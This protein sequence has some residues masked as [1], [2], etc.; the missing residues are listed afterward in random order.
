MKQVIFCNFQNKKRMEKKIK[1]RCPANIALI[2]YWGK[3]PVQLPCNPSLSMTLSHSFTDLELTLK[4][5][6]RKGLELV[7]LFDNKP[8]KAFSKRILTYLQDNKQA[9]PF[10]ED[11]ALQINT[12]NSFPYA[13]GIA[14]S[15]SAFG[16]LALALMSVE[17]INQEH[18]KQKASYYARLGSGS[19]CRSIYGQFALWGQHPKAQNSN[20]EYA[21]P[22]H[23][24]HK[25]LKTLQDAILIVD[26]RPKK[27]SSS[28]GHA[29]MEGHDYAQSRFKQANKH[30]GKLFEVLK[31]G[32]FEEFTNIVEQEALALH[33]M[34]MTSKKY[35][36]LMKP[37]TLKIIQKIMDYRKQTGLKMCFTMD[38]G[39]NV[40]LLYPKEYLTEVKGFIDREL[41]GS[42]KS[43][44]FDEA[45]KGPICTQNE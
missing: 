5:K 37:A 35:Y 8:N 36:L 11:Y 6:K 1:W 44:I 16:A 15:A 33:A 10:L 2:K 45:G 39:P 22:L 7:Y 38:A 28:K 31:L 29:L 32:N 40:H 26:D 20:N 3:R 42:L 9:F 34:M 23:S 13:A 17:N 21:V 41:S 43:T 30:C 24:V 27:V 4:E 14:S 19:A 18:F 12:T 25:S